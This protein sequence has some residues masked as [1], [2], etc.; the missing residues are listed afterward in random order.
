MHT[1]LVV[2]H[3][4]YLLSFKQESTGSQPMLKYILRITFCITSEKTTTLTL[5]TRMQM[6]Y[7]HM[8]SIGSEILFYVQLCTLYTEHMQT[9][10]E[11]CSSYQL[12]GI[13]LLP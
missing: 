1:A 3:K 5:I 11:W 4:K 13:F 2:R 6:G 12:K 9:N 7:N 8:Q 10:I